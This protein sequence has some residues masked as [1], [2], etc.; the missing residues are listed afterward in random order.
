M[1]ELDPLAVVHRRLHSQRLAGGRFERP[2]EA[3]HWLGAMQAQEFAEAKWSIAERVEGCTDAD[4]EDAFARGEILRTHVLR[5]TWHFV[6]P[7]DIRWLL[8]LT[9]PRVHAANRYWYRKLELGSHT[10]ERTGE[11]IAA[12]LGD[13][14]QLTRTELRDALA[15]AG[16]AAE[17]PR[18]AYILMHAELEELVCSGPRRGKQH[19]YA[20]LDDRAAETP[21]LTRDEALAELTRR[22]F[23]SRGPATVTDFTTWSGLTVADAEAGLQRAGKALA[24]RRDENGKA[25]IADAGDAAAG[26]GARVPGAYLIPMYDEMG[27]GYK[28][29]RVVLAKPPPRDGLLSRP[30]VIDGRTVGSWRRRVDRR[31]VAIEATLFTALTAAERSALETAVERFGRFIGLPATLELSP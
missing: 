24:T 11:I 25:W 13:G 15:Q 8:R 27:M 20:R 29:L 19:T 31:A 14:E 26:D 18:L 22:F 2:A 3:V 21:A 9:A 6:S 23:K 12:A 30:I 10:L 4:V 5:P 7:A 1:G 28:D 16:I 17:G